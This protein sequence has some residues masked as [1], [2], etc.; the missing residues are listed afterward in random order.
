M[1]LA[2]LEVDGFAA[3]VVFMGVVGFGA[4]FPFT[5]VVGFGGVDGLFFGAVFSLFIDEA[6]AGFFIHVRLVCLPALS[7]S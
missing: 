7:A 2:R 6:A 5:G 4:A 1:A 3:A